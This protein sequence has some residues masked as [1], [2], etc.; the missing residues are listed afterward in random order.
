MISLAI[1]NSFFR[2]TRLFLCICMLFLSST[3]S[4][5]AIPGDVND[6]GTDDLAAMRLAC[7]IPL[8]EEI[9][10]QLDVN[11]DGKIGVAEACL[12]VAINCRILPYHGGS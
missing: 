2:E 5:A 4:F 10:I 1:K 6:D 12:C 9:S 11:A 8:D 7:D 3:V